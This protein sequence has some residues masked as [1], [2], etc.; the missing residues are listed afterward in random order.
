MKFLIKYLPLLIALSSGLYALYFAI[1]NKHQ[2]LEEEETNARKDDKLIRYLI[3]IGAL[4]FTVYFLIG[5][6]RLLF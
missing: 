1:K 3:W 2:I 4:I 5:V 6:M